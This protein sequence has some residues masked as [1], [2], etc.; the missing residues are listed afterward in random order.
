MLSE[1]YVSHTADIQIKLWWGCYGRALSYVLD[2]APGAIYVHRLNKTD[3]SP[4]NDA[5]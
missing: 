5:G 2:F 3:V 1:Y 4:P